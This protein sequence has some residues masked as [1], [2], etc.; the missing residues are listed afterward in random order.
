MI[1]LCFR[2][3]TDF[4]P[5]HIENLHFFLFVIKRKLHFFAPRF[6]SLCLLLFFC[7]FKITSISFLSLISFF[8]CLFRF[9]PVFNF[10]FFFLH[11]FSLNI[12]NFK[13]CIKLTILYISNQKNIPSFL[14]INQI[15]NILFR[16]MIIHDQ[17]PEN[18]Q[19]PKKWKTWTNYKHCKQ[20]LTT[21]LTTASMVSKLQKFLSF[22]PKSN[23]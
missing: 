8:L 19:S 4:F 6:S 5:R 18:G 7:F 23:N 13:N 11:I 16:L 9:L 10:S 14:I 22:L 15:N 21:I 20:H 12:S 3:W 1:I 17:T 2:S